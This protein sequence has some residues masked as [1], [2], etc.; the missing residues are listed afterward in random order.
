MEQ[1][2][3]SLNA[4]IPI[5][6]TM[7][8]GYF[9]KQIKMVDEPFIKTLNKLNYNVT[10]PVLVFRDIA[11]SDFFSVWDT[12]Y[13][14]FCFLVTLFCILT[15]WGIAGI[16]LKEKKIL[17]EFVQASYRSS[18]AVMGI[19]FIQNIYGNSGMAPL[20]IIG[21]VP[22]YNIAA[23]LVLSFTGPQARGLSRQ[24]LKK[25]LIGIITNP[26]ILGILFGMMASACRLKF[27]VILNKTINNI[28]SLAT[29]LALLALGAGFEGRKAIK[30]IKPT[31]I[32]TSLKLVIQPLIFLPLAVVLGF[33]NEMLI[34]LLVMLGAPTTPSCYI[35]AKNLGHEGVLTSGVVVATTFL[36]SITLT[37]A[38]FILKSL[39]LI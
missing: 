27:P 11:G 19:A 18:A 35:M 39:G 5:F 16:T 33:R 37:V 1:L 34:A 28:A 21:T 30:L 25:S 4:T 7:M 31:M 38:L 20:M 12:K 15:I 8:I 3:F 13:V 6:L 9:L 26:I 14:L 29:P 36:S 10:L 23:V 32:T 24:A 22:L 2:F 17:G